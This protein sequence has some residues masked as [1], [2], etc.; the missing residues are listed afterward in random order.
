MAQPALLP[1]YAIFGDDRPKVERTVARLL[2][3]VRDDGGMDAERLDASECTV[4]DVLQA[5]QALSFG[6]MRVVVVDAADTWKAADGDRIA[7]YLDDPNPMTVLALV[8]GGP[9]PQRLLHAV[10]RLGGVLRWGPDPKASPKERRRWIEGHLVQEVTRLGG[11]M[12][13]SLARVVVDRVVG[14]AGSASA[15]GVGATALTNEAEKLVAYA[16]GAAIDREAVDLMVPPH[17]EARVYELA[18]AVTAGK[19]RVAYSLLQDLAT[20]DDKVAPIVVQSGL[21]RHFRALTAAQAIGP[22][23]GPDAVAAATGLKGFPARKV[24]EQVSAL[25]AGAAARGLVR[26]ARLELDLRVGAEARLG[27]SADDGQRY[28]IERAAHDVLRVIAGDGSR[29]RR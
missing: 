12:P 22:G 21:M 18:D 2:Q 27:T 28:A 20:G 25:P 10:E 16:D 9:P 24:A 7:A 3:R 15:T 19:A 5:C 17:P 13:A 26:F 8:S 1:A 6:G 29:Q 4:D 11:R 23:A 14:D